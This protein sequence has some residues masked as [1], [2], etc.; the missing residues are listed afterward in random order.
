VLASADLKKGRQLF[1]GTCFACHQLFGEG[2]KL[3]PDLTGSNRADV[4]YL[5][6]NI[7]DP[8]SLVGLDYQLHTIEKPDGQLVAG[9]LKEKSQ[10]TLTIGMLGGSVVTVPIAEIKDHKVVATSM[11]P[12]GLIA[13]LTSEQIRDLIGYLQSPRQVPLPVEGEITIGDDKLKVAEVNRGTVQQ[14]SMSG[15]KADSWSGTTHLWWTKGQPGDRIVIQFNQEKAGRYEIFGVFTKAHDYGKFR[16]KL[17]GQTALESI[18]LFNKANVVT[19][20]EL[21]LGTH[22]LKAGLN[23]LVLEMLGANPEASPGNMAGIDHLKLVPA[24]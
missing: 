14:Q 7:I 12:E 15:F 20:G 2:M 18:D 10:T 21:V 4:K 1:Q 5:L 8:S 22:E 19:T 3:G 16:V 17:N 24:K 13:N 6:E 9:L 23:Q 11:M